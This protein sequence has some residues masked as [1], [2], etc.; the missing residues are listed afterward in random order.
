M[1]WYLLSSLLY[2]YEFHRNSQKEAISSGK[3]WKAFKEEIEYKLEF[4]GNIASLKTK[5]KGG[6]R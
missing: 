3:I 1:F 6:C 2:K 4:E 5:K